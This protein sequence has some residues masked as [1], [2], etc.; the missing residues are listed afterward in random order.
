M[1]KKFWVSLLLISILMAGVATGCAAFDGEA[2]IKLIDPVYPPHYDQVYQGL[3]GADL[4]TVTE[5]LGHTSDDLT[6]IDEADERVY[7][8]RTKDTISYLGKNF[9]M[10]FWFI[11]QQGT[12]NLYAVSAYAPLTGSAA[13]KALVVEEL[14]ETLQKMFGYTPA[15]EYAEWDGFYDY[16]PEA[17]AQRFSWEEAWDGALKWR[18]ADDVDHIP[19]CVLKMGF[20]PEENSVVLVYNVG[21]FPETNDDWVRISYEIGIKAGNHLIRE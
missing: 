18:L 3:F 6:L 20:E 19:E 13:E 5:K 4:E 8:Y 2:N 14:G 9:Q 7:C 10:E 16:D 12:K 17:L 1:S 21:H 15:G 11:N